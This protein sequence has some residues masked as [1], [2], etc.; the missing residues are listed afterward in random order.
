MATNWISYAHTVVCV[1]AC[2]IYSLVED[3]FLSC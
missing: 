1:T 3:S 2:Y